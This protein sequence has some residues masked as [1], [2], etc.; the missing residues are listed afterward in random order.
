MIYVQSNDQ[1]HDLGMVSSSGE[2]LNATLHRRAAAPAWSPDG[3]K[4]A[5]Y[6][7]PSIVEFGGIYV[8]GSGLWIIEIRTGKVKLLYQVDHILNIN[9]SPDGTK[10]A[11]EVG[12]PGVVHQVFVVDARDGTEISRFAGEQPAWKSNSQELAVK[13][14]APECGLWQVGLDGRGGKLLTNDGTDSYPTWAPTDEYLVFTSRARSGDWEV[15]RLRLSD[16]ELLRLTNRPGTDTTPVFSPDGLE[17][18]LRTD[19]FGNWQ[20]GAMAVDG[21]NERVV[22]AGVGYS[23]DWG[24]ARPAVH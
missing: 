12:P 24:R 20:V 17:I 16:G 22:R 4:V 13:S 18:Y 3:T 1:T 5:F 2:L 11:F 6:G 23:D 15:Y 10:L 21:S 8:Q 7:E 14:C 9:W 19:A